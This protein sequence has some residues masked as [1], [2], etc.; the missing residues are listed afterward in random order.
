MVRL[1]GRRDAKKLYEDTCFNSKMVRL[2]DFFIHNLETHTI[3]FQF[4]NG[5][6]DRYWAYSTSA[7]RGAFQFQNGSIDRQPIS[8]LQ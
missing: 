6:I 4:Q 7:Y 8:E 5:S 2:I 3:L 1:I